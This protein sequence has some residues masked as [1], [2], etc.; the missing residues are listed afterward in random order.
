MPVSM[1]ECVRVY[2]CVHVCVCKYHETSCLLVQKNHFM[3][4]HLITKAIK[5]IVFPFFKYIEYNNVFMVAVF[6]TVRVGF[7]SDVYSN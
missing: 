5:Y 4:V 2:V 7:L 3:L 6:D 1:P